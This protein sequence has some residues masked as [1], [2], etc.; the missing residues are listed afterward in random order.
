MDQQR[1]RLSVTSSC[2]SVTRYFCQA[3]AD[4][5]PEVTQTDFSDGVASTVKTDASQVMSSLEEYLENSPSVQEND[6]GGGKVQEHQH[7]MDQH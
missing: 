1:R 2:V 6:D 3:E 4:T 7:D 5:S